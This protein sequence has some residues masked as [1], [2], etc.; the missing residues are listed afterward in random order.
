MRIIFLG[1]IMKIIKKLEEINFK[2]GSICVIGN[3]DGVHLGHKL[4]LEKLKKESV[5]L[6]VPSVLITF[7]PHPLNV[8]YPEKELKLICKR[9]QKYDEIKKFSID[10]I[11]EIKF[12]LEFS[13]MEAEDFVLNILVKKLNVKK[14]I[15]GN[16][17]YFGNKRRGTPKMLK[18]FGKKYNFKVE[19]IKPIEIKE[20]IVSSTN[21]RKF[22]IDGRVE[23]AN[24]LLGRFYSIR[25]KV[26]EGK[27]IGKSIGIPTINLDTSGSFLIKEG[28]YSGY[29]KIKG[30]KGKYLSAISV[31]KNPTF[32]GSKTI[33]EAHLIDFSEDIY[34]KEV[35]VYFFN[36]LR[37]QKK[38][39]NLQELILNIKKDIEKVKALKEKILGLK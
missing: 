16:N 20:C 10:Y 18:N 35:E 17:F 33:L 32:G 23:K 31:G 5:D 1:N 37:E 2:N 25:G 6:K 24:E 27:K 28:I 21:I 29:V 3:F 12:D 14:I 15:L 26:V 22:L 36:K 34:S 38:F 19:I 13:K 11:I 8:L 9:E 30:I 39:K 7:Y 4:I